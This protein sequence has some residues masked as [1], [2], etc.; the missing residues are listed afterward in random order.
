[1]CF[2]R[3]A[4]VRDSYCNLCAALPLWQK[5]LGGEASVNYVC[6]DESPMQPLESATTNQRCT[7]THDTFHANP[8]NVAT[9]LWNVRGGGSLT[10]PRV[11]AMTRDDPRGGNVTAGK[12]MSEG[13]ILQK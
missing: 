4:T 5:A 8:A 6:L 9:L 13:V 12:A 2:K 3:N 10:A 1:M 7:N 11:P